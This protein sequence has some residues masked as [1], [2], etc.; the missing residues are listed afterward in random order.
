MTG[1]GEGS[2]ARIY[3][4]LAGLVLGVCAASVV[5]VVPAVVAG[6]A[7]T[8][9]LC[10]RRRPALSFVG[11]VAAAASWGVLVAG[12]QHDPT[13]L[14]NMAPRIPQCE[15][16][17][18]LLEHAGGLGSLVAADVVV[19]EAFRPVNQ[20][21]ILVVERPDAE[22]GAVIRLTGWLLPLS[23]SEPFDVARRRLGAQASLSSSEA[24]VVAPPAGLHAVAARIRGGLEDAVMGMQSDRAALLSGLTTGETHGMSAQTEE[25]VRRAGLSHLVAV[26][27]HIGAYTDGFRDTL[28]LGAQVGIR[29]GAPTRRERVRPALLRRELVI[30]GTFSVPTTPWTR[31]TRLPGAAGS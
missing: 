22:V 26:S 12:P 14:E 10:L 13:A 16:T 27:G 5:A 25:L 6:C 21:G 20:A 2:L 28:V 11:L 24:E 3:S 18:R 15:V 8:T 7:A 29:G 17:G 31:Q 9:C 1:T 4:A 23:A 19:C 30:N